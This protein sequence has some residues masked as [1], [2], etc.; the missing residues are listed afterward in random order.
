MY[1]KTIL[2]FIDDQFF[3][4]LNKGKDRFTY[5]K[6]NFEKYI[7]NSYNLRS[8][9]IHTGISFGNWIEPTA[10]G[11]DIMF[12]IPVMEDKETAKIISESPTFL[13]L[14][15]IV[16]YVLLGFLEKNGLQI[17]EYLCTKS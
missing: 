13:G 2:D 8:R 9:Y 10:R 5:T 16:R 14:E 1:I 3:I 17:R 15:K 7:K 4:D 11:D 6:D 12:G